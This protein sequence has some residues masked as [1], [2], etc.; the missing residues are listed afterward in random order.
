M[1]TLEVN[2]EKEMIFLPYAKPCNVIICTEYVTIDMLNRRA[3]IY[4]EFNKN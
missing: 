3:S 1:K 2:K 4:C